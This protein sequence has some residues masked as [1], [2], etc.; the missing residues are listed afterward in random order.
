M[1]GLGLKGGEWWGDSEMTNTKSSSAA[2]VG[3]I[4]LQTLD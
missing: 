3:K 2:R 4:G 1:K